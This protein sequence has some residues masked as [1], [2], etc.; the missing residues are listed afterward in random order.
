MLLACLARKLLDAVVARLDC[1][2][3]AQS[4]RKIFVIIFVYGS[5]PAH[6]LRAA[7]KK[8]IIFVLL[9]IVFCSC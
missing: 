8:K 1:A 6:T 9:L 4:Y 2:A 5:D 7:I 3:P